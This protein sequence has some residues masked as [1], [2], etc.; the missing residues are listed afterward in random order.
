M[1]LSLF[2]MVREEEPKRRSV[3]HLFLHMSGACLMFY[4]SCGGRSDYHVL[5]ITLLLPPAMRDDTVVDEAS[6]AR[7]FNAGR[8]SLHISRLLCFS[9]SNDEVS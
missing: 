9:R 1:I 4:L 2:V 8:M 7:A 6:G 3:P 5:G